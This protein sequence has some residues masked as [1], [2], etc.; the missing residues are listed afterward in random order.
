MT[1][2][3][4]HAAF[5]TVEQFKHTRCIRQGGVE[6]ATRWL[7]MAKQ[8]FWNVEKEWMRRR[9][10]VHNDKCQDASHQMCSFLW[11]D[12]M[13]VEQMVKELIEAEKKDGNWKETRM[14]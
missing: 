1:E 7:K 6:P 5:E 12:K 11:A 8:I 4:R 14:T 10:R 13:H 2:L 9:T 3:G